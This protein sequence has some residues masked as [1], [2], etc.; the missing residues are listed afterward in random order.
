MKEPLHFDEFYADFESRG[1]ALNRP[2]KGY[3]KH[4]YSTLTHTE[5]RLLSFE[6]FTEKLLRIKAI[7]PCVKSSQ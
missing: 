1:N 4:W 5:K 7:Q 3:A 2:D 6:L